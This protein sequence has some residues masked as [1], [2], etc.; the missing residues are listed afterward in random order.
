MPEEKIA[1][2]IKQLEAEIVAETNDP[3]RTIALRTE[4]Q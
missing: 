1:A 4:L 3:D 2:R